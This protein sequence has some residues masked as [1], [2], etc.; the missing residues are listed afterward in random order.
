LISMLAAVSPGNTESSRSL[1]L[2]GVRPATKTQE[3]MNLA[4]I[5]AMMGTW[6]II[7][8]AARRITIDVTRIS[9]PFRNFFI[10]VWV[11]TKG[12]QDQYFILVF[13]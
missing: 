3:H 8:K 9:K 2:S 11:K 13:K 1:T 7:R 10:P 5:P 6:K 4:S 12:I